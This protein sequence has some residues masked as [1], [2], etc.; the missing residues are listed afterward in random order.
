MLYSMTGIGRVEALVGSLHLSIE[1]RSLNGKSLD[2]NLN[3]L[4]PALRPWDMDL[5][6]FL[7]PR[8]LR[9]TV[10]L[11][12]SIRDETP[13]LSSGI[14]PERVKAYFME[15]QS[16][17]ESLG[18]MQS[19]PELMASVLRLPEVLT[20][21][22]S[23]P[24]D[25]AD[26]EAI[27]KQ[28]ELAVGKLQEHRR[29]EGAALEIDLR[30]RIEAIEA[31][32]EKIIPLEAGRM[33]RVK[34]RLLAAFS[35]AGI[36]NKDPNRFEQELIYFLEKMDIS[37]EKT[38]LQ[39]HCRYF[40]QVLENGEV[41]KGKVLGFILQEIGREINTTGSKAND[42]G[43]QQI[44]VGMKDELEKAKEQVLNVL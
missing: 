18:V 21:P 2:V 4:A 27:L 38:R 23:E 12:I 32:V 36:E 37:E 31:G 26:W 39:Q 22:E 11:A 15:L 35:D 24:I 29:T 8:L 16:L 41:S 33:E 9:G 43:I 44:V 25:Q 1:I 10:D 7:S 40:R 13:S 6:S 42:A 19:G 3:R 20:A 34:A 17:S 28:I 30:S 14:H 5:R